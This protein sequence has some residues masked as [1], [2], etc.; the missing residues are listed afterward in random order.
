MKSS[1]QDRRKRII[2]GAALQLIALYGLPGLTVINISALTGLSTPVIYTSIGGRDMIIIAILD[3]FKS[4]IENTFSLALANQNGSVDKIEAILKSHYRTLTDVPPLITILFSD[5]LYEKSD[6]LRKKMDEI[7][8]LNNSVLKGLITEGQKRGEIRSDKDSQY[9][10]TITLS[11]FRK[12][13]KQ[14]H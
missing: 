7:I 9:L 8:A 6:E 10:A 11:S 4:C 5:E 13:M 3:H 12:T 14:L 1:T 2:T